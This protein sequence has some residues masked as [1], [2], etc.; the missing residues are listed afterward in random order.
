MIGTDLVVPA[1]ADD[2]DTDPVD[3]TEEPE[4]AGPPDEPAEGPDAEGL[5]ADG[6][7]A[8][9]APPVIA[10]G[11]DGAPAVVGPFPLGGSIRFGRT[12]ATER[13]DGGLAGAEP[14]RCAAA[15]GR[16]APVRWVGSRGGAA[17]SRRGVDLAP[18]G[19]TGW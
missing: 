2:G 6:L 16:A 15:A 17:R 3:G 9:V 19:G 1:E 13:G 10:T 8:D 7:T 4:D 18:A 12:S 11:S 14:G 5:E